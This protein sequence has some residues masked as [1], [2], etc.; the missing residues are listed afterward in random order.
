MRADDRSLTYAS[1]DFRIRGPC[2][3]VHPQQLEDAIPEFLKSDIDEKGY[4]Q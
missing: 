4:V 2:T 1:I 3:P